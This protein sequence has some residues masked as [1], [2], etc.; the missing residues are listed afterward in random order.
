MQSNSYLS[1]QQTLYIYN[2]IYIYKNGT[3]CTQDQFKCVNDGSC[4]ELRRRCDGN[5]DCS[6]SSDEQ[7]CGK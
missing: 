2:Y 6:D 4:I 5:S 1:L 7:D 3:D